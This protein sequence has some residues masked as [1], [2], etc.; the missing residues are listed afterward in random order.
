MGAHAAQE[1]RNQPMWLAS[2]SLA[3]VIVALSSV[4]L[5]VVIALI[6]AGNRL[7]DEPSV[8]FIPF[9]YNPLYFFL[10]AGLMKI[11]GVG[12]FVPRLLSILATLGCLVLLYTIVTRDLKSRV[13]GIVAAGLYAASFQFAGSWMDTAKTDSLFLFL[14][15]SAFVVGRKHSRVWRQILGGLLFVGAFYT[16]QLALLIVL[17]VGLFSLVDSR[18]RTWLQWTTA[19]VVGA[20]TFWWLDQTTNGWFSFYTVDIS[21]YHARNPDVLDAWRRLVFRMWPSILVG[22]IYLAVTLRMRASSNVE[23]TDLWHN[24]S[25]GLALILTSLAIFSKVWIYDNGFIPACLGLAMLTGLG[26]AC[27]LRS[28]RSIGWQRN[29]QALLGITALL[30]LLQFTMLA[31]DP[32]KQ[33]PT[34][35]DRLEMPK[36]PT[37]TSCPTRTLLV[38][39]VR[40]ARTTTVG[41]GPRFSECSGMQCRSRCSHGLSKINLT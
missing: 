13:P 28:I 1:I 39:C 20:A 9:A 38:A 19:A 41:A 40:R 11:I 31:Y 16:K 26:Y 3:L 12:F 34:R 17:I 8:F 15:L 18:G 23:R 21:T 6:L 32:T 24:G 29:T 10:S 4:G 35:E 30:I 5:F 33:I 2:T 27:V 7:Y 25:L 22:C 14:V 36:Q 37:Y